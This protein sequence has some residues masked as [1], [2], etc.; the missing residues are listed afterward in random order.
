MKTTTTQPTSGQFTATWEF[1]GLVW[2][3]TFKYDETTN[4][5]LGYDD[6]DDCF[7]PIGNDDHGWGTPPWHDRNHP[8]LFISNEAT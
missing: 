3:D 2:A 1:G 5:L 6:K 8:A 7:K 4:A